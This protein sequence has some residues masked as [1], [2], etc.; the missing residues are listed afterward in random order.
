L[1][2]VTTSALKPIIDAAGAVGA[3]RA[4]AAEDGP[5]TVAGELARN[6]VEALTRN[7]TGA[8]RGIFDALEGQL[9]TASAA[10]RDLLVVGFLEDLQN[11]SMNRGTSLEAW[12]AWLGPQTSV[13]W[14][15]VTTMWDG[16]LTSS[17]LESYLESGLPP[18]R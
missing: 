9:A 12:T 8:F 18:G 2:P 10:S 13:A 11:I 5:Y 3:V 17:E 7:E 14:D 16:R 1:E 6:M 4:E 15:S